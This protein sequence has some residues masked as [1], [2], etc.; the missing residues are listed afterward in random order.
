[1]ANQSLHS[2]WTKSLYRWLYQFFS[3]VD[4]DETMGPEALVDSEGHVI[5][6]RWAIEKHWADGSD[7]K[8]PLGGTS[9]AASSEYASFFKVYDASGGGTCKI[10][11]S[12]GGASGA[13]YC[14]EVK[15]NGVRVQV[16]A[17]I[18]DAIGVA[19]VYR[20]W[21][22]SWVDATDGED[23]EIVLGEVN[24]DSVPANPNSG[25]ACG[26]QLVG[27]VSVSDENG[28]KVISGI[29]QDYLRGGE[30]TELLF[31]DCDGTEIDA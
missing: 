26:S 16:P 14:G 3:T 2:L 11:V 24:S 7:W 25:V 12:D 31:S 20:V 6:E 9:A 30:H 10:G 13:Y 27:R 5:G 19:G 1:M 23:S 18:S 22:H 29:V 15:I 17:Y 21:L 28:T 4:V 8:I